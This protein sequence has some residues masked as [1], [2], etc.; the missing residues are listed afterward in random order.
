[1]ENRI[2]KDS[3]GPID[4]PNDHLWGAQT[5]RSLHHFHI[6]SEKMPPELVRRLHEAIQPMLANPAIRDKLA[7]QTMDIWPATPQQLATQLVD[8]RK[9]LGALVKASGYQPE[10]A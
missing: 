3:F 10:A 7:Q 9:R 1:M 5:Q 8:E 4:V 2:E 6:S